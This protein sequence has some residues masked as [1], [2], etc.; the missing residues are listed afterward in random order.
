MGPVRC[1]HVA[2]ALLAIAIGP[3][4]AGAEEEGAAAARARAGEV[5]LF[6]ET[7]DEI[8]YYMGVSPLHCAQVSDTHRV[9]TWIANARQRAW[10]EL[11]PTVPTKDRV[12]LVCLLPTGDEARGAD[13]CSVHPRR[14]NRDAWRRAPVAR[15]APG[16]DRGS[17]QLRRSAAKGLIDRA[18]TALELSRLVGQGPEWCVLDDLARR[19]L[20]RTTAKTEGHGTLA[21]SIGAPAHKKVR[22]ECWL[23]A[24][25]GER[26]LETCK[27][28]V[29]S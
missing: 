24:E 12:N 4:L 2:A 6:H 20:W 7:L 9:C 21:M 17:A 27:V 14:S 11:A 16:Q 26:R 23:P 18:R 3:V 10:A 19:C 13:S 1:R 15:D 22:M 8:T 25:G 28:E 5:L 29:G